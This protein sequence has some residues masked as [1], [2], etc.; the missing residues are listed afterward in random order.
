MEYNPLINID[1]F[2]SLIKNDLIKYTK[3]NYDD[4]FGLV[5]NILND[6]L[7]SFIQ[8]I[9]HITYKN[10]I[11]KNNT[12]FVLDINNIEINNDLDIPEPIK[13]AFFKLIT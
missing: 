4:N 10:L 8:N 11:I 2:K 1:I 5:I 6:E 3:N 7:N 12:I 13:M 9:E